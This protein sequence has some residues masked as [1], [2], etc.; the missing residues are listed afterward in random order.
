MNNKAEKFE[1][2][3]FITKFHDEQDANHRV[4][5]NCSLLAW[6]FRGCDKRLFFNFILDSVGKNSLVSKK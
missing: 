5:R 3:R 6:D 2:M 1:K 4:S